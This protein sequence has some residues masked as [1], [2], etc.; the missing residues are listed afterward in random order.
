MHFHGDRPARIAAVRIAIFGRI[1]LYPIF[2]RQ[3]NST[4][5]ARACPVAGAGLFGTPRHHVAGL[6]CQRHGGAN[7][8]R[9]H[10]S[11]L[12]STK[13]WQKKLGQ[14]NG[15][16]KIGPTQ[17]QAAIFLSF[18]LFAF[19]LVSAEGRSALDAAQ[20]RVHFHLGA[21]SHFPVYSRRLSG[22]LAARRSRVPL[23]VWRHPA[24]FHWAI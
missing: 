20:F 4:H 23:S 19:I 1:G 16:P 6:A 15:S 10:N 5:F 8:I 9:G 2:A 3:S 24:L 13:E 11:Y 14:K 12:G 17:S 21:F 22:R 7:A 18:D